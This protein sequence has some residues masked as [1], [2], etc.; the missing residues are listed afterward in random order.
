MTEIPFETITTLAS[1]GDIYIWAPRNRPNEKYLVQVI[2][3]YNNRPRV[4]VEAILASYIK[5]YFHM[6]WQPQVEKGDRFWAAS[7]LAAA[8]YKDTV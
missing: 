6:H 3:A 5:P 4:R 8:L 7:S 2:D 1:I